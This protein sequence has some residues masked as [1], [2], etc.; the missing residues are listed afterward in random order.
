MNLH[1][2]PATVI[3]ISIFILP[4]TPFV[5]CE[6]EAKKTCV[7]ERIRNDRSSYS[8]DRDTARVLEATGV[9]RNEVIFVGAPD[10]VKINDIY[11]RLFLPL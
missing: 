7:V 11:E 2:L 10:A 8:I 5:F 4:N 3:G 1:T 9:C 6:V